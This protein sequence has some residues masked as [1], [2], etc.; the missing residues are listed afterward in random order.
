MI[1]SLSELVDYLSMSWIVIIEITNRV[2]NGGNVNT[3]LRSY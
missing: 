2:L 1:V 3:C